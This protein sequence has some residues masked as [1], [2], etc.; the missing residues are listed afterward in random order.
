MDL[1]F[2]WLKSK[3]KRNG[4]SIIIYPND[5]TSIPLVVPLIASSPQPLKGCIWWQKVISFSKW[6]LT[7]KWG[8]SWLRMWVSTCQSRRANDVTCILLMSTVE[9][10]GF[11]VWYTLRMLNIWFVFCMSLFWTNVMMYVY[12]LLYFL[13]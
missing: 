8:L 10:E 5:V 11:F 7:K 9:A 12:Y 13:I 1:N 4:L 3:K 2:H 6:W